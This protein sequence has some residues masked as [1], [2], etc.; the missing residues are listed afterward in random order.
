MKAWITTIKNWFKKSNRCKKCR[1]TCHCECKCENTQTTGES[2][3]S[4]I[5]NCG[6]CNCK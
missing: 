1:H 2:G 3:I 6:Q 4:E 5:C